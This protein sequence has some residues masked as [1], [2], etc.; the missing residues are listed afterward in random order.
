MNF[1][2]GQKVVCVDDVFPFGSELNCPVNGCVYTIRDFEYSD[3]GANGMRLDEIVNEPRAYVDGFVEV[4]FFLHRFRP[5]RTTDISIFTA[6]LAPIPH[7]ELT[8]Q[9]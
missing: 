5:V 8:P 4:A 9:D 7:K 1:H 2:V 6:M 3:G